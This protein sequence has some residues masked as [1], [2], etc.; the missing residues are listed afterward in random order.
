MLFASLLT[1]W[2]AVLVDLLSHGVLGAHSALIQH[3]SVSSLCSHELQVVA[4]VV[5][6][7]RPW[8]TLHI[9]DVRFQ[10]RSEYG[11]DEELR[12]A[13]EQSKI[14]ARQEGYAIS[15]S[16]PEREHLKNHGKNLNNNH[17]N[18]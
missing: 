9:D 5:I 2:L 15:E 6:H 16:D 13:I 1:C 14:Q 17:N 4:A 3:I 10:I 8:A 11:E 18:R 12:R 7:W